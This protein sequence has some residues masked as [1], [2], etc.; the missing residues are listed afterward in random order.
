MN[1]PPLTRTVRVAVRFGHSDLL[2]I[3]WHGNYVQWLED[4]RQSL[5][6]A[7]G[8][9]YEDLLREKYA[10]PIVDMGLKYRRPARY[11]DRL[12]V[13]ASLHWSEVPKLRHTYEVRRVADGE[14]LTTAETT[15]VLLHPGG[16]LVLNFPPFLKAIRERWRAGEITPPD[17]PLE[18]WA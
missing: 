12:D 2:R 7:I 14:L 9:G 17:T 13:T 18:T 1:P 11:G 15:Q 10:A 3:V 5:G 4:A 8:L 16:D 6:T